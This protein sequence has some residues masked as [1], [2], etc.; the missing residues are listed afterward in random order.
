MLT[1]YEIEEDEYIASKNGY[2]IKK[3]EISIDYLPL[4]E[5]QIEYIIRGTP[6][7]G[8][9][10]AYT[11]PASTTVRYDHIFRDAMGRVSI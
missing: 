4:T 3:P 9:D 7:L 5:T 11:A 8:Y 6:I 2:K 10:T 1:K